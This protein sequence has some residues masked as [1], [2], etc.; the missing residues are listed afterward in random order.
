MFVGVLAFAVSVS[1]VPPIGAQE[2]NPANQAAE[3]SLLAQRGELAESILAAKEQ[4]RGA[5]FDVG[6]H[7]AHCPAAPMELRVSCRDRVGRGARA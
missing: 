4:A 2:R 6:V 1:F 7:L 3:A 5:G